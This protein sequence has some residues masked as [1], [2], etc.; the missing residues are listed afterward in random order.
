M[1][2]P[3]TKTNETYKNEQKQEQEQILLLA[4]LQ[5]LLAVTDMHDVV[6][7][8]VLMLSGPSTA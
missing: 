4:S 5:P 7:V 8:I 3:I 2:C 1:G 6:D